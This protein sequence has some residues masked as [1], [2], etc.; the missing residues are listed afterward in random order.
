MKDA[1]TQHMD[2]L[3]KKKGILTAVGAGGNP[4]K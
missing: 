1:K 4:E 2:M 3:K